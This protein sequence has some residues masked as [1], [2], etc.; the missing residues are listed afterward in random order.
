MSEAAPLSQNLDDYDGRWVAMR[1]DAVVACGDDEET[2][3][4]DP[5]V[6]DGDLVYPIG[7]PPS[8]FYLLKV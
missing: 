4:S 8:G 2:V 5:N 6:R 1:A 7:L 3:R